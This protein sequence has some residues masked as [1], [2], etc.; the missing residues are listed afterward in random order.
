M[1]NIEI[2]DNL[3]KQL[4]KVQNGHCGNFATI[5]GNKIRLVFLNKTGKRFFAPFQKKYFFHFQ[6]LATNL[7]IFCLTPLFL[8]L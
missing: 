5:N 8:T 4:L 7:Q 2:I 1:K 6:S 3:R